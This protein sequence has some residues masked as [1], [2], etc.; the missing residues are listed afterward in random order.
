MHETQRIGLYDGNYAWESANIGTLGRA[1]NLSPGRALA[2]RV[3]PG[4]PVAV[5]S[6]MR[7][8]PLARGESRPADV[9][10]TRGQRHASAH[11]MAQDG[12]ACPRPVVAAALVLAAQGRAVSSTGPGHARPWPG[13]RHAM[14]GHAYRTQCRKCRKC[15]KAAMARAVR[16]DAPARLNALALGAA[17]RSRGHALPSLKSA[18]LT[19]YRSLGRP[20]VGMRSQRIQPHSVSSRSA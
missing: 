1:G 15:N 9:L 12:R 2:A 17:D 3:R 7:P 10:A 5:A 13:Q 8:S 11:Q 20:L 14:S 6:V 4:S 19:S 16:S 18:G